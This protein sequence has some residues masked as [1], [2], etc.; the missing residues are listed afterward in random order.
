MQLL[1]Q[2]RNTQTSLLYIFIYAYT[3]RYHQCVLVLI[4]PL[5]IIVNNVFLCIMEFHGGVALMKSI[6]DVLKVSACIFKLISLV[7]EC[8]CNDHSTD[9]NYDTSQNMSICLN[10]SQQTTGPNC[11]YCTGGY[12]QQNNT[13]IGM[14]FNVHKCFIFSQSM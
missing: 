12:Y 11:Q 10:C 9:C 3:C 8:N 7:L 14:S 2:Q 4:I 5:E 13:C 1:V 6:M